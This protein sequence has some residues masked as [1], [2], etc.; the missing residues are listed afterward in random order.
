MLPPQPE[1]T[2]DVLQHFTKL[3]IKIG[4]AHTWVKISAVVDANVILSFPLFLS[5]S[6]E[7]SRD[8]NN[9]SNNNQ[10]YL[11]QTMTKVFI[12]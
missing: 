9:D 6:I 11:A 2:P 4:E 3:Y 1:V 10:N 12:C 5:I 8:G 7:N